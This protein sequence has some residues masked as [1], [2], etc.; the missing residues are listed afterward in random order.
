M[1]PEVSQKQLQE[2]PVWLSSKESMRTRV[3]SLALLSGLKMWHDVGYR[4]G[5]DLAWLWLW[6]WLA[7]VA[8][9]TPGL[10]NF[11][12]PKKQGKK[13]KKKKKTTALK[14]EKTLPE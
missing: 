12:C 10:G 5:S 8:P 1:L 2:F 13:K 9:L 14:R 11:I 4:F 6:L 7:A 3:P